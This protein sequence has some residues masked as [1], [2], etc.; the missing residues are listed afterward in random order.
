MTERTCGSTD[1]STSECG[2]AA[3][4]TESA[5]GTEPADGTAA[6]ATGGTPESATDTAPDG[7]TTTETGG[8]SSK[9][10]ASGA[11]STDGDSASTCGGS[12]RSTTDEKVASTVED[13]DADPGRLVAVGLGPGQ[14]EGMTERA[15]AALLAAEHVVGY[16]TYIDL[17]PD[18]V[19]DAADEL[20]DTPM[21]GEVS[22]TEEAVDRAL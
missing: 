22:R 19:T 12:K 16:T 20:Y 2:G 8:S 21:C 18:E 4:G 3:D 7:G 1:E 6:D 15:R 13:F 14:P 17:L 11:G 9:C 10:G 5:D